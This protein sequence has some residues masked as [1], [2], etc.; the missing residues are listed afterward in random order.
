MIQLHILS[1]KQA[2]GE[3][4]VRRFP[5]VIGRGEA[6]LPLEE[7]GVWERHLEIDFVR[8]QGFT[9]Q[10]RPEAGL[11]VNHAPAAQGLLRNGDLLEL[12]TARLRFWLARTVQHGL[13]VREMLTWIALLALFAAQA[14]LIF[15]LRR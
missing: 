9:F 1:G 11:L 14:A 5:F 3:I 6:H 7:A 8:G 15:W 4:V 2:G 10:A 12:G 13:R